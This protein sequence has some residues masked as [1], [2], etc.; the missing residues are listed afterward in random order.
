[1]C[2]ERPSEDGKRRRVCKIALTPCQTV[3]A[4]QGDFAHPTL[5]SHPGGQCLSWVTFAQIGGPD[6]SCPMSAGPPRA[7]DL[8]TAADRSPVLHNRTLY[9]V[10]AETARC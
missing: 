4:S 6:G 7:A 3:S 8:R 10:A 9:F 2:Q 5:P 1:M